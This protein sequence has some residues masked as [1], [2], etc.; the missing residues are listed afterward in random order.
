MPITFTVKGDSFSP[1]ALMGFAPE[2][3]LFVDQDGKWLGKYIP[4]ALQ[5]YPFQIGLSKKMQLILCVDESSGLVREGA[6]G[7]R[8]FDDEG[9]PTKKIQDTTSFLQKVEQYKALTSNA[10]E[11]MSKHGLIQPWDIK[12]KVSS[13]IKELR[14]YKVDENL[15]NTLSDDAFLEVRKAGALSLIYSQLLSM[16]HLS[17]LAEKVREQA[18]SELTFSADDRISFDGI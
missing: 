10:C 12:A 17:T 8:F 7:L 16:Q 6:K 11:V 13:G 4:T 15:L 2:Q 3:N 9:Q 14:L 5:A 1:V 18:E